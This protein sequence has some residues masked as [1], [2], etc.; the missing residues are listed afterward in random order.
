MMTTKPTSEDNSDC[1][2]PE[3]I[4]KPELRNLLFEQSER[5]VQEI[6]EYTERQCNKKRETELD[7]TGSTEIAEELVQHAEK[8]RT[9]RVMGIDYD[10]WDV[11]TN[12]NRWWVI[13]N[14]TNLYSQTLMP[15]IDY[16]LSFHI[17]LM[18]RVQARREL[19]DQQEI[20]EFLSN[21][22]R[23][24]YQAQLA[25]D[26]ADEIEEFQAIGL[27]CREAMTSFIREIIAAGLFE[28][29]DDAPKRGD[30]VAWSEH[31]IGVCVPGGSGEYVR[32]YLKSI[33]KKGWQLA[34][35]LTHAKGAT[36]SDAALCLHATEHII[37][38]LIT[39]ALR[40]A[41][42]TPQRCGKCGSAKIRVTWLP[43]D[44]EYVAVCLVCDA[45][46]RWQKT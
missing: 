24:I 26:G 2:I 21:T 46:G 14:A 38:E 43:D 20:H 19:T 31:I 41:S 9:E 13:T 12:L 25:L 35:W 36:R 8:I 42:K 18:A 4:P 39:L 22:H 16:T 10:V 17:G 7:E 28:E 5:E 37:N 3:A 30:F 29:C 11:H 32:G 23:K 6:S 45:E 40:S 34:N 15:S 27:Q 33:C 44:N 1:V